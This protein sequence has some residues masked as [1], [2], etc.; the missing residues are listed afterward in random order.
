MFVKSISFYIDDFLLDR[1]DFQMLVCNLE[2]CY[3]LPFY[4]KNKYV[5]FLH[6]CVPLDTPNLKV[7]IEYGEDDDKDPIEVYSYPPARLNLQ[8]STGK[9]KLDR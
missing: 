4:F 7:M 5:Y 3:K 1:I 6:A 2:F 9:P 8:Q